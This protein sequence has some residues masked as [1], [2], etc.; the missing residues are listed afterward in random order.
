MIKHYETNY[1]VFVS[2]TVTD[3]CL[4]LD[5]EHTIWFTKLKFADPK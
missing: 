4:D 5:P 1:S 3:F 2:I